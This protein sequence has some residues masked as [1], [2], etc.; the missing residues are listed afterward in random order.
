[1]PE[2]KRIL[3]VQTAFIGDVILV[4]PLIRE[5]KRL[6]PEAELDILVIPETKSILTNNPHLSNILV[7]DK[8]RGKIRSFFTVLSIIKNNNYDLA[9]IPHSSFTTALLITLARIKERVGY[10]RKL[11]SFL[12]TRLVTPGKDIHRIERN[13]S[14]LHPYGLTDGDWQTELYPSEADMQRA[15]D[16]TPVTKKPMIAIAPGSVWKTKCW[17]EEYYTELLKLINNRAEFVFIGARDEEELCNKIL[18]TSGCK[19]II[20]AGKT[21]ILQSAAVMSK[22]CCIICND[23]G[24]LHLANAMKTRVI[25]FFGPTVQRFGFFPFR[26][27]DLVLETEL[28]CRPC[29]H[30]GPMKCPLK[31]HNCMRLITPDIVFEKIRDLI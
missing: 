17:P 8:K 24:A 22:C 19:G 13:L 26:E 9:L 14:L 29:G 10:S 16:L 25:A 31:H 1:M 7:F 15:G 4:T 12:M 27:G 20:L 23:S 2:F 30:H 28:E 18:Q 6:F 3:I 11:R 21:S 5:T